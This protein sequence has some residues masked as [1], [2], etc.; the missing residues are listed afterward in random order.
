MSKYFKFS[1]H[2]VAARLKNP[3]DPTAPIELN[4][5]QTAMVTGL[6]EYR[7]WVHL[8]ARRTGKSLSASVIALTKLLEPNQ[9]VTVVAPNYN[10]S[11]I[12]W[13]FVTTFI[14]QLGIETE[15]F[16]QK[17]KIVRLINGSVFRLLSA[18]NRDSLIGRG[19]NLLIVDE[20]AVIDTDEYF[21]RDLRP[22]LSTFPDSRA[23][24]ITTPRGKMNYIYEYYLRGQKNDE[25]PDWGSA[26]FDWTANPYLSEKDIMEAKKTLPLSVFKQEYYCEWTTFEGQIYSIDPEVHNLDLSYI[27]GSDP[28]Y[29]FIAGL[30]VGFR[31]HTAFVVLAFDGTNYFAVDEFIIRESTTEEIARVIQEKILEW[32]IETIYIDAAAAQTKA[33][34]AYEYD[35]FC[36]NAVKSVNDG[37]AYVQNLIEK[38]NLLFDMNN[39]PGT[40]RAMSAYRWNQKTE[41]QKPIHDDASHPSDAVRYAIYTHSKTNNLGIYSLATRD[42]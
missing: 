3:Y 36:D 38:N 11:S 42:K 23:L 35:I 20:A 39:A 19:A 16:N 41:T 30:D 6:S 18:N 34:L 40:F 25:Y 37:I 2:H 1:P 24:F 27:K 9:Q 4:R 22:A 28:R 5:S 15:R 26:V 17:D 13:D 7:F 33:D 8:S 31:D 29:E 12:I 32:G 10:L 21:T 14:K